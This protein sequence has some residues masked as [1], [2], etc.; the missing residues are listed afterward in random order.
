MRESYS[1]QKIISHIQRRLNGVAIT[2]IYSTNGEA[3]VQSGVPIEIY[4][5]EIMALV[6][7]EV[8]TPDNFERVMSALREENDRYIITDLS[9]LK[10]HEPLQVAKINETRDKHGVAFFAS[11]PKE[12]D[13]Y[14]EKYLYN[15]IKISQLKVLKLDI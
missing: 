6:R 4:G 2:G 8:K 12:V 10:K 15:G 14:L 3:D 1:Q 13:Y 9:K 7:I 11:T 5:I